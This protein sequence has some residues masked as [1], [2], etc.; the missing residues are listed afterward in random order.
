MT[1]WLVGTGTWLDN[2]TFQ[3]KNIGN[4]ISSSHLTKAIIF[5]RGWKAPTRVCWGKEPTFFHGIFD[6]F[7]PNKRGKIRWTWMLL[8]TQIIFDHRQCQNLHHFLYRFHQFS[9][10]ILRHWRFFRCYWWPNYFDFTTSFCEDHPSR[11]YWAR[12]KKTTR[13]LPSGND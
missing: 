10:P 12:S 3:K 8:V 9:H 5:Q 1:V 13:W 11:G 2:K 4:G 6:Q 7:S